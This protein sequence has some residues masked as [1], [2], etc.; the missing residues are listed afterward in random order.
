MTQFYTIRKYLKEI[1]AFIRVAKIYTN[2]LFK[3]AHPYALR[4]EF[5]YVIARAGGGYIDISKPIKEYID[6]LI[7]SSESAETNFIIRSSQKGDRSY[8]SVPLTQAR[9]L[10]AFMRSI[11]ATHVLEIGTFKGFSTAFILFAST[12]IRVIAPLVPFP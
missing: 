3:K 5:K 6:S 2:R 7:R 4:K 8:L 1:K 12:P 10:E 9:F 11:K